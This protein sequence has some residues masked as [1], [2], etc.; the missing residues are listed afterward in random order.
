MTIHQQQAWV[1]VAIEAEQ[2]VLGAVLLN[3]DVLVKVSMV[4]EPQHFFDPFHRTIFEVTTTLTAMGKV[5]SIRTVPSFLPDRVDNLDITTKAYLA[6]LVVEAVPPQIAFEYAKHVR[7][8]S[9]RRRIAEIA[10]QMAPDAATDAGQLAAEAIEALDTIVTSG[11]SGG[12]PAAS[13]AEVMARSVEKVAMA[14]QND[15]RIVGV[16]TGLRDIDSKTGGLAPGNLVVLAGRPGMGKSAVIL[17]W[18]RQAA[19]KGYRSLF[20]SKEMSAEELGE[21][22]ISDTIFDTPITRLPYTSLRTGNFHEKLFD[23]VREAAEANSELPI[24][25]EEQPGLTMSQIA[26]RARRY[27]RKHGRLDLVAIDHLGLVK[28]TVRYQGNRNNEITEITGA[29]KALAKELDCVVV[30]LSQLSRQVESREDKRPM[31]A[32]LRDSGS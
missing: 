16:P 1:P 14:Y 3:N 8:M 18:M 26:T 15:G 12:L 7:E 29:A 25:V 5:A 2:S 17:N 6:R 21:R 9:D 23:Y 10:Q 19:R 20:F 24:D 13:M 28:P 4:L 11:A 30:L 22:M 31:L 27:K 32:D